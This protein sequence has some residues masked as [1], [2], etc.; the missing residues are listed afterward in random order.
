MKKKL[1]SIGIVLFIITVSLFSIAGM[2]AM[3]GKVENENRDQYFMYVFF[4]KLDP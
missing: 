3:S 2:Y 1:F 4:K